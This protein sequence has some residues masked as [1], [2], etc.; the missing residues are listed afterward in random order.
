MTPST[1]SS[2]DERTRRYLELLGQHERRLRGFILALVPHWADA[3]DIAQEV[4]IRLWE[5]FDNYDPAKDFG[6]WARTVAHYRVLAHRTTQSRHGMVINSELMDRIAK[7]VTGMS[8]EL[9]EGQ[10]A[11]E[12][13]FEKLPAEKREL[14]TRY[15][16]GKYTTRE[17]A[18]QLGRTFDATRQ[19]ILRT[20]LSLRDCV[21]EWLHKEDRP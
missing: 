11:L 18:A 1:P 5:Q 12:D 19:T 21:E 16:S 3:E 17:L 6:V 20:R 10:R 7:Q 4:R 2:N 9:E 15:Y 8:Q 13:C 14:L